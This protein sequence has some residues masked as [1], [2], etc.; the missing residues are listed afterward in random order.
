M[1]FEES[2]IVT[3]NDQ[4]LAVEQILNDLDVASH[5]E[6]L[7]EVPALFSSL[8][9]SLKPL[10]YPTLSTIY[11]NSQELHSHKFLIDAMPLVGTAAAVGVAKDMYMAGDMTDAEADAW[12]TSL[13]LFKNPTT[14]VFT[15]LAVSINARIFKS[16]R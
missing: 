1:V 15:A 11:S 14:D 4:T 12:F 3:S 9:S 16:M 2:D 8:V 7:P 13:A 5:G 10:D 6:I